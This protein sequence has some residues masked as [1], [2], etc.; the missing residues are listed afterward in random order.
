MAEESRFTPG[1]AAPSRTAD[2]AL[3]PHFP[4]LEVIHGPCDSDRSDQGTP[5]SAECVRAE[6]TH[7][8]HGD[9]S[10]NPSRA[11]LGRPWRGPR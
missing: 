11:E 6:E 5:H 10:S 7:V 1:K 4:L 2:A 9:K 3:F 8:S